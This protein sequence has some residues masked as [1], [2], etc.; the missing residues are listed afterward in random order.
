MKPTILVI[1]DESAI[2]DCYRDKLSGMYD[3]QVVDKVST[4]QEALLNQTYNYVILDLMLFG[5]DGVGLLELIDATK[6][7][8]IIC[9]AVSSH[10][11]LKVG[12]ELLN[13]VQKFVEKPL[14]KELFDYLEQEANLAH[15]VAKMDP[16]QM[17]DALVSTYNHHIRNYLAVVV[18]AVQAQKTELVQSQ[19]DRIVKFLKDMENRSPE[20]V[21]LKYLNSTDFFEYK[22]KYTK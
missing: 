7:K 18:P 15:N 9:S 17:Y 2:V 11:V 20:L 1:E 14:F 8:T 21:A 16:D 12:A 4:A 22:K 3:L 5:E 13:K 10:N 6:T 19:I